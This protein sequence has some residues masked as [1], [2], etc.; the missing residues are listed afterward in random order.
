MAKRQCVWRSADEV[1]EAPMNGINSG[2]VFKNPYFRCGAQKVD[3]ERTWGF[4]RR[5]CSEQVSLRLTK[6]TRTNTE[7][8][9]LRTTFPSWSI[10]PFEI[11]FP[12]N[13]IRAVVAV[14]LTRR[15]TE[16]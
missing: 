14:E 4:G 2:W 11:V 13:E 3:R 16:D 1:G 15:N 10:I 6:K 8:I 5:S 7:K 12:T 9:L